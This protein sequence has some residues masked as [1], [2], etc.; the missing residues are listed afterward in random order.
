[1]PTTKYAKI[2]IL[3][4][5]AGYTQKELA[6]TLSISQATVAQ[7]ERPLEARGL[8]LSGL[9]LPRLAE[10]LGVHPEYLEQKRPFC[11]SNC[12][13]H[14]SP[15]NAV[16]YQRA[17][18]A[19]I[20]SLFPNLLFENDINIGCSARLIDGYAYLL[21][22]DA[23]K[24]IE[25]RDTLIGADLVRACKRDIDIRCLLLVDDKL[26]DCFQLAFN[27]YGNLIFSYQLTLKYSV[28]SFDAQALN[29]LTNDG[30]SAKI[31]IIE[32]SRNLA[33]LKT[34]KGSYN[35]LNTLLI[36]KDKLRPIIFGML[37]ALSNDRF[38]DD[39]ISEIS[40]YFSK[41]IIESAPLATKDVEY[42]RITSE[43]F[44]LLNN[45]KKIEDGST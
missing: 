6:E 7:W 31:D 25:Y 5:L 11:L 34:R 29:L 3:R 14:P 41:T 40:S 22:Y 44:K 4:I 9:L 10:A 39:A 8:K 33:Q 27:V 24:D 30:I 36:D 38:N 16:Q 37:Y 35:K 1:M 13:W 26:A 43:I 15:P 20:I 42:T 21:G 19:D 23:C 28:S 32:F 18:E 17:M 45:L 2:K 12:V